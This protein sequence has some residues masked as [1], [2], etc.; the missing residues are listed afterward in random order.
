MLLS[1]T[2][3]CV[4]W[5]FTN[6]EFNQTMCTIKKYGPS[7]MLC[8]EMNPF[9]AG[10]TSQVNK[11]FRQKY[12]S[13][14]GQLAFPRS[15]KFNETKWNEEEWNV[16]H[17]KCVCSEMYPLWVVCWHPRGNQLCTNGNYTLCRASKKKE[18]TARKVPRFDF[19]FSSRRSSTICFISSYGRYGRLKG[20]WM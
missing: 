2:H 13:T 1:N 8:W 15:I 11:F 16:G 10:L 19:Q 14:L 4:F 6:L 17:G 18:K 20:Y 7:K 5:S 3:V 9:Q 12:V